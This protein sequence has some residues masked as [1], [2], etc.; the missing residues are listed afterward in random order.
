MSVKTIVPEHGS[1]EHIIIKSLEKDNQGITVEVE[2]LYGVVVACGHDHF[3]DEGH[4]TSTYSSIDEI[5][6]DKLCNRCEQRLKK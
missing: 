3:K 4:N 2:G 5:P 6:N 1:K